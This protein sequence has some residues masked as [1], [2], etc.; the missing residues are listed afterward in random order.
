[1][2]L[3]YYFYFEDLLVLFFSVSKCICFSFC[4]ADNVAVFDIQ[5]D[6]V[7][8]IPFTCICLFLLW[9]FSFLWT[10]LNI[11]SSL[12]NQILKQTSWS[13]S[14]GILACVLP[15]AKQPCGFVSL[16]SGMHVAKPEWLTCMWNQ[17]GQHIIVHLCLSTWNIL[18]VVV[19][20][21]IILDSWFVMIYGPSAHV[22]SS[23]VCLVFI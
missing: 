15:M 6:M 7:S 14:H 13:F 16:C 2:V 10:I 18:V 5:Q 17:F 21:H 4:N 23:V 9:T 8:W 20:M 11:G 22:D 1:M 3:I 12:E 19:V